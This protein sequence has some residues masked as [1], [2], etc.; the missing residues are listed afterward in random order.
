[1]TGCMAEAKGV[2]L[3]VAHM[4]G[5]I[6]KSIGTDNVHTLLEKVISRLP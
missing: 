4:T 2:G 3:S 5:Q 6:E 1:M